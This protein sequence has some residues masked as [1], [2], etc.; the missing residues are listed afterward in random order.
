MPT[1]TYPSLLKS[2]NLA[3]KAFASIVQPAENASGKKYRTTGCFAAAARK[4]NGTT[5]P[6]TT[7]CSETAGAVAP[8]PSIDDANIA[9][10]R[11]ATCIYSS[12]SIVEIPATLA[13]RVLPDARLC[14]GAAC[15][16]GN[17]RNTIM[18]LSARLAAGICIAVASLASATLAASGGGSAA[19]NAGTTSA[20]GVDPSASLR[21]RIDAARTLLLTHYADVQRR[22]GLADM[23]EARLDGD[24]SN[25]F[26]A[27]KPENS[28][29]A[30][31]WDWNKAIVDLDDALVNQIVSGNYHSLAAARGLDDLPLSTGTSSSSPLTL[32][33]VDVPSGY[34]AGKPAPL[35]VL[36]HGRDV[37]EA[38]VLAEPVFRNLATETGAIVVAPLGAGDDLRAA[39]SV[40]EV[41]AALDAAEHAF[42]VDKRRVY[43]VGDSFGGYAAFDIATLRPA[44]WAAL[45]AIRSTMD[46]ADQTAVRDQL[47]GK[48]VYVVTGT[49][50]L[51]VNVED[52]R[53]SVAWFRANGIAVSYYEVPGAGHDIAALAPL[54]QRA[55]HEMVSGVHSLQAAQPDVPAMT[56][57]PSEKP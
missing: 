39:A 55:W 53:R 44:T 34:T 51:A 16:P 8:A 52:V 19:V 54:V 31:F 15:A 32:C 10:I 25:L 20:A 29:L 36:L 6:A 30:D 43:L 7:D 50:D 14:Q 42:N 24:E 33:G 9:P 13:V 1:T 57:P 46:P 41:Y 2:A 5:L 37:S 28:S 23:V 3:A 4:S 47:R 21:A 38:S 45:L 35:V 12:A 48:A 56:P 26:A 17:T 22:S 40:A 49:A 11:S 27:A 18:N